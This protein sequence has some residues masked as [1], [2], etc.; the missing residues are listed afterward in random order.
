MP[1]RKA[2]ATDSDRLE[3]RG[4]LE[5]IVAKEVMPPCSQCTRSEEKC[6][7]RAGQGACVLC[8][9][10]GRRCDLFLTR[11]DGIFPLS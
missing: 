8:T 4:I 1:K 5:N 3:A 11:Q 10:L 2:R 9:R 6:K 7:L